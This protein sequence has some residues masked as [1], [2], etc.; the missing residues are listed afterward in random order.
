MVYKVFAD[1][2]VFLDYLLQR[3]TEWQFAEDV[4]NLADKNQIELFISSS[5]ML[6]ILYLLKQ[7]HL[8]TIDI[9]QICTVLLGYIKLADI[10][11]NLFLQALHAGFS[12]LEDAVQYF[13]ALNIKGM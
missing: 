5:S 8:S 1:T 7:E 10:N 13:T 3:T 2:N 11:E 4:F 12:D 9:V 6:N